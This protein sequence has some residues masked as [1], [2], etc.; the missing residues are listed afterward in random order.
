MRRVIKGVCLLCEIAVISVFIFYPL[1]LYGKKSYLKAPILQPTIRLDLHPNAQHIPVYDQNG[2]ASCYAHATAQ[3]IDFYRFIHDPNPQKN[4]VLT[5][6]IKLAIDASIIERNQYD[7]KKNSIA[8]GHPSDA[9]AA[10]ARYGLCD[11]RKTEPKSLSFL[12]FHFAT[13]GEL[14]RFIHSNLEADP[15]F[16]WSGLYQ[17]AVKWCSYSFQKIFDQPIPKDLIDVA[18]R[19]YGN[20][21]DVLKIIADR[22]CEPFTIQ[23]EIPQIARKE[24]GFV[25]IKDMESVIKDQL[26]QLKPVLIGYCGSI[27]TDAKYEGLGVFNT[28]K[29]DCDPHTSVIVGMKTKNNQTY[30]LVRNSWGISCQQYAWECENGQ[31]WIPEKEL[32]KNTFEITYFK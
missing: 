6:P 14:H 15:R 12:D 29:K 24:R 22:V 2:L 19:R 26:T 20:S 3:F 16:L 11:Y 8:G 30:F 5:S 17:L 18:L 9:L 23:W 10:A 25:A 4:Q 21:L 7:P 31:I 32:M 1:L 28:I 13:M 27:L